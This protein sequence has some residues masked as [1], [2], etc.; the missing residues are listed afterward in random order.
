[1]KKAIGM[2]CLVLVLC[3]AF[4]FVGCEK[5]SKSTL[6]G[7]PI[8]EYAIVYS[9]EENDYNESEYHNSAKVRETVKNNEH[10]SNNHK[11]ICDGIKEFSKICYKTVFSC[12]LSVKHVGN[13]RA[14]EKNSA[15]KV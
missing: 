10:S 4:L 15:N 7:V 8:K 1:M 13:R 9:A 2:L 12:Y 14:Y 11:F 3:S 6:C 5:E